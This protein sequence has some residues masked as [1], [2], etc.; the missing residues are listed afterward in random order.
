MEK[1]T[2]SFLEVGAPCREIE[3][4]NI[5]ENILSDVREETC[6]NGHAITRSHASDLVQKEQ[7]E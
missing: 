5:E 7:V 6:L 3:K 4:G 1:E 2:K